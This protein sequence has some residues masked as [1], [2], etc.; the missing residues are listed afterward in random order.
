MTEDLDIS[1]EV[2]RGSQKHFDMHIARLPT[3]TIVDIHVDIYRG[4]KNGPTLMLSGGL[5]GDEVNGIEIIRRMMAD[6]SIHP[7]CGTVIAVPVLNIYGFLNFARD[8]PDGKDANRSFPGTKNGS[9][10]S[11]VAY[12]VKNKLLPHIDFGVDFHTGGGNKHNHPQIRCDF[13]DKKALDLAKMFAPFFI[14]NTPVISGSLRNEAQS[15]EKP[16][17]VYEAGEALRFDEEAIKE[18]IAGTQ[19]LMK[20]LGM[21]RKGT[22]VK[23]K[24]SPQIIQKSTW[25]RAENAGLF[26]T[27]LKPGD[28]IKEKDL[29]GYITDP[30]NHYRM[31]I[32]APCSGFVIGLNYTP[33]INAGDALVHIGTIKEEK[34]SDNDD[35]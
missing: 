26:H 28:K 25:I 6:G 15:L 23:R 33:V 5:H 34:S 30:Y 7:H 12:H 3:G 14:V 18:G 17:I 10:A 16:I 4:R 19:R 31:D 9:L 27:R 21:G 13:S 35:N 2:A 24:H 20:S 29:M 1:A 22:K 8:L 11:R 32:N